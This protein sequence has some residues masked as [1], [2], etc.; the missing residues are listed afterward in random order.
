M[1]DTVISQPLLPLIFE[2]DSDWN[3]TGWF[4]NGTSLLYIRG[5]KEN[6][7]KRVELKRIRARIRIKVK[8]RV[9]VRV[10]VKKTNKTK[11]IKLKK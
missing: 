5:S 3:F 10:R 7:I 2:N 6:Y 11:R 9:K 1:S 4:V 8:V